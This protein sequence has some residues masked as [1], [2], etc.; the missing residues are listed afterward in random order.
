[1]YIGMVHT[2]L[3]HLLEHLWML[4]TVARDEGLCN[5]VGMSYALTA[6]TVPGRASW[7]GDTT[8]RQ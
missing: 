2:P 1:M 7:T 4:E 5:N 6:L 3:T 8:D